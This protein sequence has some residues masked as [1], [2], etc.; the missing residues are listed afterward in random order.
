MFLVSRSR[1]QRVALLANAK[2]VSR[3][4]MEAN[5]GFFF[6][7]EGKLCKTRSRPVNGTVRKPAYRARD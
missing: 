7:L 6:V 1:T 2:R 3:T 4:E 5:A